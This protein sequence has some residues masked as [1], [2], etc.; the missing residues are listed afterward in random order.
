MNTQTSGDATRTAVKTGISA[1][2][3]VA[4]VLLPGGALAGFTIEELSSLALSLVDA[5]PGVV[6]AWEDFKRASSGGAA[7][8]P[9]QRQALK[10]A[11]DAADDNLQAD[12]A[13][14]DAS[15]KA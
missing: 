15:G 1:L 8:T 4:S 11:I 3:A 2:A 13:A 12:V 10:T 6:A 9:E 14:L 7:P 5:E